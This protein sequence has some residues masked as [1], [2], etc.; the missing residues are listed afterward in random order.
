MQASP[1]LSKLRTFDEAEAFFRRSVE[2]EPGLA[3]GRRG[4]SYV[5]LQKA[6]YADSEV[7]PT[8]LESAMASA[9]RAVSLDERDSLFGCV[10][11]RACCLH[12][13]Y[14]PAVAELERARVHACVVWAGGRGH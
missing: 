10:L 5:P 12:Q 13:Q 4:L 8:L 14:E 11:G 9:R 6:F 1:A 7:R 3:R 2:L